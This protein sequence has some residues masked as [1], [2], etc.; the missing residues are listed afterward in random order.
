MSSGLDLEQHGF[1]LLSQVLSQAECQTLSSQLP[2][3]ESVSGGSRA[4]LRLAWCRDLARRLCRHPLIT[5]L[6]PSHLSVVQ[7]TYFEKSAE[8]NWAVAMHQDLSL[9]VLDR[10]EVPALKTW[11][12]KEG[13]WFVQAPT[14]VLQQTIALR[15]HLEDCSLSDGALK[16]LPGT[17][18]AGRL[19]QTDIERYRKNISEHACEARRGDVLLMRP[20]L[21][22]ASPKAIGSGRR[23]VLHFVLAP[24]GLPMGLRSPPVA[25]NPFSRAEI[26]TANEM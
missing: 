26:E 13:N 1:A 9:P 11:S 18:G 23:R 15:V 19:S 21:L 16:V 8:R 22:H 25:F 12:F 2:L 24:N 6:I 20:L 14:S 7:C 3:Y 5:S 17:H 10:I 4:M